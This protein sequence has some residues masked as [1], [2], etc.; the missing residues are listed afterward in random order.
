MIYLIEGDDAFLRAEAIASV[1]GEVDDVRTHE[2]SSATLAAVLDDAR[3]SSWIG[4][5]VV[6]VRAA[7]P[8]VNENAEALVKVA[9]EPI[10]LIL[11]AEKYDKRRKGMKA[12]IKASRHVGCDAPDDERGL[13][14]F[15]Q[16]RAERHG[17]RFV[18]GADAALVRRLGG[19]G[20]SCSALDAEVSKLA[21][22]GLEVHP[23]DVEALVAE[24]TSFSNFA[25]VDAVGSGDVPRALGLLEAILRDGSVGRDGLRER[26]PRALAPML[27]G[28]LRWDLMARA[29]R[30][31]MTPEAHERLRRRHAGLREAD[32]ALKTGA[33]AREALTVLVT[34]LAR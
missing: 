29:R 32:L 28:A 5:V 8:F 9:V 34:R 13:L 2:G 6:R 22:S 7:A 12:L 17:V 15:V 33:D 27:L 30:L 3:N 24:S 21:A 11:E 19:H 14:S 25:L 10:I 23:C 20:L 31:P 26:D 4:R 16:K 18:E 1:V